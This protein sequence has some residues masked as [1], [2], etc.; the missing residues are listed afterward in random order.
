MLKSAKDLWKW[1]KIVDFNLSIEVLNHRLVVAAVV[2]PLV[3]IYGYQLIPLDAALEFDS[4]A[5][6]SGMRTLRL[7]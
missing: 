3:L 1:K 7:R 6:A 2:R 4:P 5:I